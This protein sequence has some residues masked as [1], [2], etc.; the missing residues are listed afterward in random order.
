MKDILETG[1]KITKISPLF[2]SHFTRK[3]IKTDNS[4]LL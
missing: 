1:Q 3:S 2:D 4:G